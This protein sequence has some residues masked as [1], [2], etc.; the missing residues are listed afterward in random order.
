MKKR[1]KLTGLLL[2]MLLLL[3]AACGSEEKADVQ[4]DLHLAAV[5]EETDE[6]PA[7]QEEEAATEQKAA[8]ETDSTVVKERSEA[9]G[10]EVIK[11]QSRPALADEVAEMQVH[12]IDVGQGDATLI[13]CDGEA[14]LIDAGDDSK[15]TTVQNYLKKQGVSRLKYLVLTH[16]D[17]DHIGGSDVI[18]SKFQVDNVFIG[19]F[20]KE[21]KVYG[22]LID[23]LAYRGY[24]WSTP[25]V[26]STYTLGTAGITILA[27]NKAYDDPN[28]CSIALLVENGEDS[29]LFTGDAEGEAEA[30]ILAN[31]LSVDCDVFKAGHHGSK[32]SNSTAFLKAASPEITVISCGEGNSYGHPHAATLNTLRSMGVKVYR[33][34]EQGSI[35]AASTGAGITW[36][37]APSETWQAGEPK[38]GSASSSSS[39]STAQSQ[40]TTQSQTATQSQA[41]TQS[42]TASQGSG[43][44]AKQTNE[45]SSAPA[46]SSQTTSNQSAPLA[47]QMATEQTAPTPSE[48]TPASTPEASP[49]PAPAA[50]PATGTL[51]WKSATGEKYHSINNCGRMNPAKATQITKEQA[52]SMGLGPCSKCY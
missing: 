10:E 19:D 4:S 52:E 43:S 32:T 29:F 45:G 25:E 39:Q 15:G 44:E 22:D 17:A 11:K 46:A 27:P 30:D 37:A 34:D 48:Q 24:P 1:K 31:G 5:S 7:K 9:D 14:M 2:G 8:A 49:E 50:E 12:F 40:A 18:I 21:S 38:G 28:N 3:L 51:V 16:T 6:L 33:T 13:L 47:S 20:P 36:N 23:A 41:I 35:I 26:G 42:Q